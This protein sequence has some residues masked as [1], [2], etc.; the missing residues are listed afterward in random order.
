MREGQQVSWKI[1]EGKAQTPLVHPGSLPVPEPEDPSALMG[2][3]AG[4]QMAGLR[5]KAGR[6]IRRCNNK[7]RRIKVRREHK[8]WKKWEGGWEDI[9]ENGNKRV[10]ASVILGV[11][12]P[13]LWIATLMLLHQCRRG[14][15]THSSWRVCRECGEGETHKRCFSQLQQ[16]PQ[17][18]K[19][20]RL[21]Y[22]IEAVFC[23]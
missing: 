1:K 21:I 7:K 11:C 19:S 2:L 14:S 9:R 4:K 8:Q 18:A 16:H 12:C 15:A 23:Y 6:G 20:E 10:Q 3:E 13:F 22:S 17:W 5:E